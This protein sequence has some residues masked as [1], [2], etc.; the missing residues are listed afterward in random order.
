MAH[1]EFMRWAA[2]WEAEP[3]GDTRGDVQAAL[4]AS[5]LANAHRD[6][7]KH[8]HPYGLKDFLPKWWRSDE[9]HRDEGRGLMLKAREIFAALSAKGDASGG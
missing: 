2:F 9:E 7:K 3:W 1:E 4:L 5:I 8:P 6:V